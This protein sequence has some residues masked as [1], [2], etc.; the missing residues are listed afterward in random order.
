MDQRC[1]QCEDD[2]SN[3]NGTQ[4][5]TISIHLLSPFKNEL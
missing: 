1:R 4:S 3:L 2:D 5:G